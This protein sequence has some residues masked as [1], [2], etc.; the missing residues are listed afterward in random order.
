MNQTEPADRLCTGRMEL[1]VRLLA[2]CPPRTIER[3]RLPTTR[4]SVSSWRCS[5]AHFL[6]LVLSSL[7][8]LHSSSFRSAADRDPWP[9]PPRIPIT[10]AAV[11]PHH[12]SCS[13]SPSPEPPRCPLPRAWA[14][15]LVACHCCFPSGR[16]PRRPRPLHPAVPPPARPCVA[17]GR[18]PPPPLP[19]LRSGAAAATSPSSR[20]PH[21]ASV[22]YLVCWIG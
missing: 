20:P 7:P 4:G 1:P 18:F 21:S 8:F 22:C 12:R 19:R 13:R 11:D 14:T 6:F 2:R 16:H 3:W 9:E 15:L 10:G 5:S 17:R